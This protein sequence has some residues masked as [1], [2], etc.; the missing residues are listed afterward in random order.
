V[1]NNERERFGRTD[2]DITLIV[3]VHNDSD[4]DKRKRNGRV[5]K[6]SIKTAVKW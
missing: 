5:A 4:G 3:A 6:D 2:G 1:A